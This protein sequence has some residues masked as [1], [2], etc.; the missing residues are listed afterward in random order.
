MAMTEI[1]GFDGIESTVSNNKER[2]DAMAAI[3]AKHTKQVEHEF[4]S[5]GDDASILM[6]PE[7]KPAAEAPAAEPVVEAAPEPKV[8]KAPEPVAETP[9]E[10]VKTV[11]LKVDGQEVEVDEAA[12]REAGIKALQKDHA[13]DRRLEESKRVLAEAREIAARLNPPKPAQPE[14]PQFDAAAISQKIRFGSEEESV[15]AINT[16]FQNAQQNKPV[17][18]VEAVQMIVRQET[19]AQRALETFKTEFPEIVADQRLLALAIDS[20][21]R[22]LAQ[23]RA[24]QIAPTSHTEAYRQHGAAI[25]EWLGVIKP[26]QPVLEKLERKASAPAQPQ[27]ASAKKAAPV[28]V[29]EPTPQEIVERYRKQRH[30]I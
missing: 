30:Q 4:K 8:E 24:G 14:P 12:V 17:L 2:N 22:R 11:K 18:P 7:E 29:K 1:G 23:I 3:V 13:A 15:T 6:P 21:N 19:E 20:E 10:P 9:A 25:R 5:A 16:L 27:A 26:S 28:E